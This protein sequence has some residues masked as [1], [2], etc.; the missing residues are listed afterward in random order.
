[1]PYLSC[2]HPIAKN[3]PKKDT[4]QIIKAI[5]E[6]WTANNIFCPICGSS[7][8]KHK[9]DRPINDLFCIDCNND[10]ELKASKG[11]FTKMLPAGNYQKA[12]D[13]ITNKPMHLFVLKYSEDYTVTNFLVVPKYFF[14]SEIVK[15]R[16]NAL[17]DRPNYFMSDINFSNIPESG[18]IHYI[19]N[20]TYKTRTEILKEWEKIKFLEKEKASSKGWIFDI[21]ICIEKLNKNEFHLKELNIF[22]D[23]L[24]YKHPE[25]NN[26]EPKIRQQLQLLRNKGYLE[27]IDGKG[28]YRVL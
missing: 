24:S 12:I 26:I 19:S 18:K 14:T 2:N 1:M 10:F 8:D 7:L 6:H 3:I 4:Q 9:I 21:M 15:K 27:F 20:G 25:N 22:I 28:N 23:E 13:T 5:T 11:K 17:K 16:P